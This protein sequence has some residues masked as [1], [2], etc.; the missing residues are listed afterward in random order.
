MAAYWGHDSINRRQTE[1]GPAT[2]FLG[3]KKRLEDTRQC[4]GID[5]HPAIRDSEDNVLPRRHR[6]TVYLERSRDL[7]VFSLDNKRSAVLHRA[8]R[9]DS[10]ID[11]DLLQLPLVN[12]NVAEV[13]PMHDIQFN[14]L[15]EEAPRLAFV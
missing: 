5:S 13:A 8:S 15:T 9:I 4:L 6:L 11:N 2:D 12:L 3:R 1:S 7:P 14:G 10:Q